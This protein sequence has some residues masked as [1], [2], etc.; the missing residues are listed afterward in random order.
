MIAAVAALVT[1]GVLAAAGAAHLRDLRGFQRA[2]IDQRL[3][4]AWLTMPV[5]ILVASLEAAVGTAGIGS[6]AFSDEASLQ[7][8]LLTA[9]GLLY[10]TYAAFGL[11][12]WR[13]RPG[14][15]CGCSHESDPINLRV[16]ARA[17]VLASFAVVALL[18]VP[19][20]QELSRL[21][22]FVAALAALAFGATLWALPAALGDP[23]ASVRPAEARGVAG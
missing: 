3:W 18:Y 16:V 14:V 23:L 19:G 7:R 2:F 12:L 17:A 4:A 5:A 11:F 13:S 6:I 9:A 20:A 1:W 21:E 22:E 15:P 8:S 10:A